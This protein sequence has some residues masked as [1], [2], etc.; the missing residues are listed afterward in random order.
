MK[1]GRQPLPPLT[2]QRVEDQQKIPDKEVYAKLSRPGVELRLY[3]PMRFWSV[4]P[5][6][7]GMRVWVT[8]HRA[9]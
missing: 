4:A 6:P 8:S 9:R 7:G 2:S 5:G 1:A 3:A